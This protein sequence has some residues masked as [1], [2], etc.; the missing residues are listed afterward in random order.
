M[1]NWAPVPG[2]MDLFV[3]ASPYG[4]NIGEVSWRE[5]TI[6]S[7]GV[8]ASPEDATPSA[9]EDPQRRALLEQD[10]VLSLKKP[11]QPDTRP[12]VDPLFPGASRPLRFLPEYLPALAR[13]YG[14]NFIAD[15]Y[16]HAGARLLPNFFDPQ[17][18]SARYT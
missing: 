13:T 15:A 3:L 18:R 8:W 4:A 2:L 17:Y 11:Y 1:E 16:W 5:E 14:V 7:F 9:E 10:P 6:F 12:Y